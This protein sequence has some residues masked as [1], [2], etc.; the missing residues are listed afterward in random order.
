[1]A[2]AADRNTLAKRQGVMTTVLLAADAVIYSGA[3]VCL[4][5]AG[6][7]VA[8]VNT[9]NFVCVGRAFDAG[10]N[11]GGD[12]GDVEIRV[13]R[14]VYKWANATAGDAVTQAEIGRN[15]YVSDD[16]T[17]TKTAG[18]GVVAGIATELDADGGVWVD[19]GPLGPQ[20]PQGEPGA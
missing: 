3:L 15:V 19:T 7:A 20:G 16:Q 11:T 17:V 12:A 14:G 13:Q 18:N 5:T 10:D 8:G 9:A 2:L 6:Y 4:N 1:M